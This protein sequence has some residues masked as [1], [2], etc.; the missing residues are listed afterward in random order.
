MMYRSKK[1]WKHYTHT[2][3]MD[4]KEKYIPL[5]SKIA[6]DTNILERMSHLKH[7]WSDV[8]SFEGE[9]EIKVEIINL[10]IFVGVIHRHL[11]NMTRH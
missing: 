8:V 9:N 2:K 1:L 6:L 7:L 5:R 3:T 11:R 4:F 10:K